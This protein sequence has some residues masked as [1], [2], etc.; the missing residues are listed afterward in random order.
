MPRGLDQLDPGGK[1]AHPDRAP[2]DLDVHPGT[3]QRDALDEQGADDAIAALVE[4]RARLVQITRHR[5]TLED[6][7]MRL[8]EEAGQVGAGGQVA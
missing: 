7:F 6:L 4:A 8:A 5:E 3:G 2:V 1:S